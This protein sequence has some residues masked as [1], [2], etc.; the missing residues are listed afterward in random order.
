M[1]KI[2]SFYIVVL[3]LAGCYTKPT[4]IDLGQIKNELWVFEKG[5]KIGKGD[6]IEFSD[7]SLYKLNA[8]SIYS[9]NKFIGKVIGYNK[10]RREIKISNI[11]GSISYY[12]NHDY[13]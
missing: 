2:I 5:Y 9:H 4:K 10:S 13:K 12:Y 1:K 8:D 3:I 11:N 6:F 7:S